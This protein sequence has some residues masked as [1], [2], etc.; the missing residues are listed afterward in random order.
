M[1]AG[2]DAGAPADMLPIIDVMR[3]D[4]ME[5]YDGT[6]PPNG[7]AGTDLDINLAYLFKTAGEHAEFMD[8]EGQRRFR[9]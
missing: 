1:Y 4:P 8:N 3:P 5:T 7:H 2:G 9:I 6:L